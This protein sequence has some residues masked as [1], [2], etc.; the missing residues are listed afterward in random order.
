VKRILQINSQVPVPP[1]DGGKLSVWGITKSLSKLGYDI[2][3]VCYLKHDNYSESY[4][5]LSEYCTPHI[6]DVKTD[7]SFGGALKNLISK[8]PYNASKYHR[9]ELKTF[10]QSF[11]K[12]NKVDIVQIEH[13]HMGW[14][15]DE[16][17][18][19][20]NAKIV[21]RQQ[22]LETL[23][24]KRYFENQKNIILKNYAKIQYKKFISYEPELCSKFDMCVMI[25]E[26]DES[27][28]KEMNPNIKTTVIPAGVNEELF[29]YEKKNIIPYSLVHI[30]QTDWYPNLDGLNWFVRDVFP[31]LIKL[32]PRI[33]LFIYGGGN[34]KNYKVPKFLENNIEVVGFVENLWEHLENKALAVIPL[35]IGGGIRIKILELLAGGTNIITTDIGKEGIAVKDNR[36][37]IIANS[38]EEFV[39]KILG[40]FNNDYDSNQLTINGREFIKKYYTWDKIALAFD[41]MYKSL[42]NT[43]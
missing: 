11:L 16:I 2:D 15:I 21:L 19:F 41:K 29:K 32:E 26:S 4:K 8:V 1:T 43:A 30:G 12:K 17:R 39:K 10:V 24:M 3:F 35:R 14:I 18:K 20:S 40:Y 31:E 42:V 36:E 6:L 5:L 25:S 13:L 22:N 27:K 23:I 7:N 37:L 9:K 38:K 33:K 34:T 28:L